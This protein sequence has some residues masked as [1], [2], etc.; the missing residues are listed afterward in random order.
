VED[1]FRATP[2][3]PVQVEMS[4]N[5]ASTLHSI[6]QTFA[7]R[8]RRHDRT[9]HKRM[10]PDASSDPGGFRERH[11]QGMH[12][13]VLDAV[14][15]VLAGWAG[16]PKP[17]L[18]QSAIDDWFI[19]LAHARWLYVERDATDVARAAER[20]ADWAV[21]VSWLQFVQATLATAALPELSA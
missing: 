11:E 2:G 13:A 17:V 16:H 10:L 1:F 14:E 9:L 18:D 8:C 20:G 21:K 12:Q 5:T 19:V 7:D 4:D 6:V 3:Q 15:R